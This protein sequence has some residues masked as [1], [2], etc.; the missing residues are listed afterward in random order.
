MNNDDWIPFEV[1][2]SGRLIGKIPKTGTTILVSSG[3][4]VY[5]DVFEH[6]GQGYYSLASGCH[7]NKTQ[8]WMPFPEPYEKKRTTYSEDFL[9]KFPHAQVANGR[10]KAC[11]EEIYK[12][13]PEQCNDCDKCWNEKMEVNE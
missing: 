8:A 7:F 11:R 10:P 4:T 13:E 9:K 5:V 2:G 1:D 6:E 12:N 3:N